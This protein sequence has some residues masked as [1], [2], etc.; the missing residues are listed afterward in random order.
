[1]KRITT[2][3]FTHTGHHLL[4]PAAALLL[5]ACG[6]G[7]GGEQPAPDSAPPAPELNLGF[8]PVKQFLF[9]WDDVASETEYRLLENPDGSSG[10]SE[11]AT[12][13]A[14]A[15][16]HDLTVFLPERINARYILEACNSAGCTASNEVS[17]NSNLAEAV[18]YFKASN[19]GQ[20]DQFGTSLA[21]SGDGNTLAVGG[22]GE[23]SAA[24]GIDSN[25]SN[26]A[27]ANAGAVYI[28]VHKS[29]VWSQQA[30]IKAH[31]SDAQDFFGFSVTL[32]ADG[33][34][35]AVGAYHEDGDDSGN[36]DNSGA[37][38]VFTRD[39]A[40]WSQQ[41]YLKDSQPET[42]DLF[43]FA[44]RL[45]A[46]GDT[47]AV[48]V[49]YED[50][51]FLNATLEDAGKVL[52][53]ERNGGSWNESIT[54]RPPTTTTRSFDLFGRSI[55]LSADGTTLAVGAPGDDGNDPVTQSGSGAAYV[56]TRN[57]S[58]WVFRTHL[59]APNIGKYDAF[60]NAIALSAG[61]ATL[62]VAA[63]EEDGDDSGD[64]DASGAVYVFRTQAA[65]WSLWSS[66]YI[67]PEVIGA[68]DRFGRSLALSA[69]GTRLA[70]TSA[71][72]DSTATGINGDTAD[73]SLEDSGAAYLFALD[74]GSW[75]QRA[76]IK[77]PNT[78]QSDQF[79]TSLA[80]SGDGSTLAVGGPVEDS[81]ATGIGGEQNDDSSLNAGA[82]YLY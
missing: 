69:D 31:N 76:Y 54:I 17:V 14:D 41:A 59:K 24:T 8:G 65:D 12:L 1:M 82:V 68:N 70:V 30:Y 75:Q 26:N 39:G 18:G 77:A 58:D 4:L 79:G 33:D 48:G 3:R 25:G 22:P 19:T 10:F 45:S 73:N 2:S 40:T 46:D 27:A 5:A 23:D 52:V 16:G 63:P 64:Q 71:S 81:A 50:Y 53:F 15:T 62:A 44:V 6:G 80:L 60:G 78:G 72:E 21:L 47:L 43:G 66:V 7:G 61:G 36:Q 55:A 9:T 34:T 29:G 35:L 74:G 28:F 51:D 13:A 37:V 67:K 38:Y 57:G 42:L 49:P 20:G 56:F 32:S 11:V